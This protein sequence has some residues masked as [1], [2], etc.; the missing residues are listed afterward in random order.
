VL[1]V[2]QNHSFTD[3]PQSTWTR[4]RYGG[5]GT[6]AP[7]EAISVAGGTHNIL[8]PG[9]AGLALQ[10]MG[11]TG[12]TTSPPPST[13]PP[14]S[15]PP[16]SPPPTGGCQV[17]DTVSAWNTGLTENITITNT[18]TA[19]NGWSLVFTLPS[20]QTITSGWN[21][22]YRPTSGQVTAT[23]LSY[24][25]ALPAGSSTTIGFQATHTGNTARPP[26][27]TLNGSACTVT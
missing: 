25:G 16:T 10:F 11:L 3:H 5:T 17:S 20:G 8:A 19:V 2:G 12:G 24:N 13:A 22:T 7:V 26:A 4:T 27:F 14:T 21:A 6:S 15:P 9:M 18:G 23:N 1:G